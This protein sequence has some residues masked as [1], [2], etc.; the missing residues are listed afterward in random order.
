M[1]GVE[2]MEGENVVDSIS[3]AMQLVE[4]LNSPWFKIYPDI[5]NLAAH[6]YDLREELNRGKGHLIGVHVKDSR[7]DEPRRVPFGAGVVPFV[8]AFQKLAE[9][10]YSGPVLIEMWNDNRPD[11]MQLIVEARQWVLGKMIAGGL[12]D[13]AA[14]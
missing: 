6:G 4:C 3:R 8:A 13:D 11:S 7:P 9:M 5:G 10:D 14:L 1:L 12:V 2:T